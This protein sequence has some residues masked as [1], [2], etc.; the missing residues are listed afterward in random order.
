MTT[1][2]RSKEE[3][4]DYRYFPEPDLVA[5]VIDENWVNEIKKN[6]PELPNARKEKYTSEY[7]LTEYDAEQIT[8][9]KALSDYFQS[10]V[11]LGATPKAVSN[12][13]LSD[14]SK[15]LNEKPGAVRN[16]LRCG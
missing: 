6:L 1:S 9:S 10:C 3:A 2:M 14:I 11:D 13:I 4:H 7:G 5:I 15:L 12:W 16:S 8:L